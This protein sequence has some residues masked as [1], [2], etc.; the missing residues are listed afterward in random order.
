MPVTHRRAGSCARARPCRGSP[1]ATRATQ[2]GA[3][4]HSH[5]P[6]CLALSPPGLA[7]PATWGS[8][9]RDF[10]CL[11]VHTAGTEA[12]GALRKCGSMGRSTLGR[13]LARGGRSR[14]EG[15]PLSPQKPSWSPPGLL[16]LLV[17]AVSSVRKVWAVDR[18]KGHRRGPAPCTPAAAPLACRR[19]WSRGPTAA[20]AS[21]SGSAMS[22]RCSQSVLAASTRT[23][24]SEIFP[25]SR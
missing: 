12:A 9:T 17:A 11:H 24:P 7:R 5:L 16:I 23:Q 22:W 2:T 6:T 3:A 14:A 4:K 8:P 21:P 13:C 15:Q 18:C 19:P 25:L 10:L 1:T 20:R